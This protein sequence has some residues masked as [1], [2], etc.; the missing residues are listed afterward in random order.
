MWSYLKPDPAL[1]RL[2]QRMAD[3]EPFAF[4]AV[5]GALGRGQIDANGKQVVAASVSATS[6]GSARQSWVQYLIS[7]E[8]VS[9]IRLNTLRLRV[10]SAEGE[11]RQALRIFR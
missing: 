4:D 3:P 9:R 5:Y 2:V 6:R 1:R 11:F 8:A 7:L 10:R